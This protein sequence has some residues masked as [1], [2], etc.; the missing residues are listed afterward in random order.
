MP[1]HRVGTNQM[2]GLMEALAGPPYNGRADLPALAAALQ[3][4]V[5]ELLPLGET[6]QLL[7]FAVL[8]E[9]DIHLTEEGRRFVAADTEE[10]KQLFA[11][12]LTRA[13]A[14]GADDPPGAGRALEPPRLGG[15]VPRRAGGPHVAGLRGGHAAHA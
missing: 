5:D 6:L 9:G 12:A 13:R 3:Y 2:A 8:E 10:R 1:L 7:R 11:A 14:A 15:A 4:E